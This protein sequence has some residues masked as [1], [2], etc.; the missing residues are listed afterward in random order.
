MDAGIARRDTRGDP[1]NQRSVRRAI[2]AEDGVITVRF[3][4][5]ASLPDVDGTPAR[6]MH[7]VGEPD[8]DRVFVI[9]MHGLL[10]VVGPE[11]DVSEYLDL[12]SPT[13]GLEIQAS[14]RERGLQSFA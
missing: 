5:Y 11:G 2:P 3:T 12:K 6:A 1:D 14:S 4:E 8:G 10:Y 9:D 7:L 13:W